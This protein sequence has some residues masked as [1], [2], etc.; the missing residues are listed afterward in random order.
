MTPGKLPEV[1][2]S[3]ADAKVL[4]AVKEAMGR[5]SLGFDESE[6]SYCTKLTT[7]NGATK[8]HVQVF[9]SGKIVI[10]GAKSGWAYDRLI[11]MKASIEKGMPIPTALPAEVEAWPGVIQARVPSVDPVIAAFVAE[12]T[13]AYKADAVLSAAFMLGAASEKAISVLID[14]YTDAIADPTN[15]EKFRARINNRMISV[16][17]SEFMK[18]FKSAQRKPSQADVGHDIGVVIES[19]FQFFRLT[20]NDVG[21]PVVVPEL[22]KGVVLVN[23]SHFVEYV[24]RIYKLKAYFDANKIMV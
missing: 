18:S 2:M 8:H 20:R 12:A 3:V 5:M 23:L 24:E 6:E 17:F 11:E 4:A 22:D 10:Q 13:R 16:R 19:V 15:A 21:H 7:Q 9:N 1:V 14:A